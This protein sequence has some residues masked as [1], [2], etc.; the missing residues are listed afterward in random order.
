MGKPGRQYHPVGPGR[1]ETGRCRR[2]TAARISGPAFRRARRYGDAGR[3]RAGNRLEGRGHFRGQCRRVA[4]QCSRRHGH[5][6]LSR[7]HRYRPD[8]ADRGNTGAA[9]AYYC[10]WQRAPA[11][12]Q[13]HCGQGRR[14]HAYRLLCGKVRAGRLCR[15]AARRTVAIGHLGPRGLPGFRRHR[16]EPQ[17]ADRGW[18][19]ARAQR[20]GDR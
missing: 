9:A 13:F 16:R 11:V 5:E 8:R 12:H 4:A 2:H 3:D 15:C 14:A 20:Q 19:Q 17:C 18:Q 7:D 10:A 6:R 1:S